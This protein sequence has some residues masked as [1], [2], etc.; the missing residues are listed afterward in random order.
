MSSVS[1]R[2]SSLSS[3]SYIPLPRNIQFP[4]TAG[5]QTRT[6][7]LHARNPKVLLIFLVLVFIL[8][9]RNI[10]IDVCSHFTQPV[11]PP[12]PVD[13]NNPIRNTTLGVCYLDYLAIESANLRRS[14][15]KSLSFRYLIDSTEGCHCS[16]PLMV[17]TLH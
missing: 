9:W 15:K 8:F 4:S 11:L 5:L 3:S 13:D 7:N 12:A 6:S 2:F 10:I 1:N 14:L 17:Q 16:L